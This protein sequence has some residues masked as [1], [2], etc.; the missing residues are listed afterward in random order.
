MKDSVDIAV[1]STAAVGIAPWPEKPGTE[2]DAP[3]A[4]RAEVQTSRG[5]VPY[6]YGLEPTPRAVLPGYD[7]AVMTLL[8]AVFL[9]LS[10]NFRS[11]GIFFKT[12]IQDLFK[13]RRRE[14]FYETHTT[15]ETRVLLALVLLA[16]VCEGILLFAA[17]CPTATLSAGAVF[18]TLLGM[19]ALTVGYYVFQYVAYSTVGYVFA[20]PDKT[21]Q[22]LRGFNGSQTLLGLALTIPALVV[23]FNP[24]ATKLLV[25]LGVIL[26][27]LARIVFICKGFRLFYDKFE[28]L[29]YFILYLCTLE[30][31]P[32]ILAYR[33]AFSE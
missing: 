31:I 6:M 33:F 25:S 32:L 9:I 8:I 15:S 1:D 30:I 26:Y 18:P 5:V 12:Y 22:W 29:L 13:E 14:A 19:I 23:L 16:T 20:D 3:V 21:R 11:Y 7:S 10:T 27:F 28:S 4:L 2:L 24:G 17:A